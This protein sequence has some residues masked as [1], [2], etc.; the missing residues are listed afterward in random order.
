MAKEYAEQFYKSKKWQKCRE[1][2][3][4]SVGGLCEN[5][6]AKGIYKP[7]E[8]VHH[9][10][11]IDK[12]NIIDASITLDWSNLKY[13]CRDCHAKEHSKFSSRRYTINDDGSV[14][15]NRD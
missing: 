13:V 11:H 4:T 8:I 10:K 6:L 14:V 12:Q 7:G 15:V 3:I 2:Y 1:A 5:C 9:I